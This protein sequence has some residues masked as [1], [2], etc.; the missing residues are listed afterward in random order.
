[1]SAVDADG[2]N[3]RLIV[4]TSAIALA[5][6]EVLAVVPVE[7]LNTLVARTTEISALLRNV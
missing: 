6:I 2:G 1:M 7:L 5:E 4:K 3:V